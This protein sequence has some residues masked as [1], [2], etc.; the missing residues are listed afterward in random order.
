MRGSRRPV[1]DD[2]REHDPITTEVSMAQVRRAVASWE[3]DLLSGAGHVSAESSGIF[4]GL[5]ITWKAR[6]ED[7]EGMTSPE[8]LLA[9]AHAS[10]FSMA[11]SNNLA[12]AGTPAE[13]L[14]VSVEVT[15]DKRDAGWTVLSSAITVRGRVPGIDAAAFQAAAEGA[16]DGCPISRALIGN[17]ELTVEAILEA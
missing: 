8:E 1:W 11:C 16:K 10:C 7:A 5:P 15:A 3:G 13:R 6:T 12:K 2:A 14:E 17:V 9:A 4:S